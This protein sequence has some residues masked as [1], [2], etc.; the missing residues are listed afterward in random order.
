MRSRC[1]RHSRYLSEGVRRVAGLGL[2][3]QGVAKL[4]RQKLRSCSSSDPVGTAAR[5]RGSACTWGKGTQ[6]HSGRCRRGMSHLGGSGA[7]SRGSDLR[8][9]RA[10]C[11]ATPSAAQC[12]A[13]PRRITSCPADGQ[14]GRNAHALDR[15]I[16]TGPRV[17]G[18][19]TVASLL[20]RSHHA[21]VAPRGSPRAR[22]ARG[23]APRH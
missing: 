19:A 22:C 2:R 20:L 1:G 9:S 3:G 17:T 14:R 23:H 12:H 15:R 21:S 4:P 16:R 8:V 5:G 18:A 7:C 11:A 10:M 13:Q 6:R